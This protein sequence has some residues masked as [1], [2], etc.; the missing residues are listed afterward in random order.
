[1][2]CFDSVLQFLILMY[3]VLMQLYDAVSVEALFHVRVLDLFNWCYFL[4]CYSCNCYYTT[5]AIVTKNTTA[6]NTNH[7]VSNP[8]PGTKSICGVLW[9]VLDFGLIPQ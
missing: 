8:A 5:A 9:S 7:S 1:M 3:F 4:I 2:V 6:T